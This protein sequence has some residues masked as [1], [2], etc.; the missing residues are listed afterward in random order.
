MT[1]KSWC[2][3]L[4]R[5]DLK[6]RVWTIAWSI[7]S[8]VFS[9]VVPVALDCSELRADKAA[10]WYASEEWLSKAAEVA[11][12][13]RCDWFVCAILVVTA[14]LWAVSGFQYLHNRQKVDFY[15]SI[16]VKR[17][18]LFLAVYLNGIVVPLVCYLA[19]QAAAMC[20]LLSAGISMEQ[21]GGAPWAGLLFNGAYYCLLYTTVVMAMMMTGNVVV[22]L[23]GAGVFFAYGPAVVMLYTGYCESYFHSFVYRYVL[24]SDWNERIESMLRYSS[25][26]C[27]YI[28][29]AAEFSDGE[30]PLWGLAGVI[31]ATVVLAAA[32]YALY[33]R[34][35]SEA[36]GRAMAFGWLKAPVR[37]LITIPVGVAAGLFFGIL[38]Q[39]LGWMVFGTIC[40]AVLCHCLMEIIYH[41]DFR[42][43]FAD[44]YQM[45]VCT[46]IALVLG[47][48]GHYDLF[49]YD[50]WY[51]SAD[52]I[53]DATI[54]EYGVDQWVTYGKVKF[55]EDSDGGYYGW[56]YGGGDTYRFEHMKL[57]DAYT[58]SELIR[59]GA[60]WE[61]EY[62]FDHHTAPENQNYIIR[63]K[64][65]NGRQVYRMYRIEMDD[66][67]REM[68]ASL[69]NSREYK[70]GMYPV[71]DQPAEDTAEVTFAQYG[72]EG[73]NIVE[74]DEAGR[75]RLL[76]AFK[77]DMLEL[78]Q[79]TQEKEL[80]IGSIRFA[81][82]ELKEAVD[83]NDRVRAYNGLSGRCYYPV[84]P[85]F[86]RTIGLLEEAGVEIVELG[87]DNI[88]AISV[89]YEAPSGAADDLPAPPDGSQVPAAEEMGP[90]VYGG[91]VTYEDEEDIRALAPA[92]IPEDY[93]QFD[94]YYDTSRY[95]DNAHAFVSIQ[96]GGDRSADGAGYSGGRTEFMDCQLDLSR[97][98]PETARRYGLRQDG[99]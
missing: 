69:V 88:V 37:I 22:A 51:P 24:V 31:L 20:F 61:K 30:W 74:L 1:S 25:P 58:V 11:G 34:R 62:R 83:H 35:P 26:L 7:L 36:A 52:E 92:L 65:K 82:R 18:Q 17:G 97:I 21:I 5:E 10:G 19:A 41:F 50:S 73:R 46:V 60:A 32:V 96:K 49:G 94:P 59:R 78:T 54:Y 86:S 68:L 75:A 66:E 9:L 93:E 80:P 28:M 81:D 99:E 63:V 53:A 87:T 43:L 47:V 57:T 6:R 90:A 64:L 14:V 55:W 3:K 29:S 40:G 13:L 84:Y 15:H 45:V 12:K 98:P 2:F 95:A 79:S 33:R 27:H 23:L 42:K 39:S 16:P 71:L 72:T 56:E 38:G 44:R 48:A 76:E 85:S 4:M 91:E 77:Q 67:S 8:M 89:D 70:E